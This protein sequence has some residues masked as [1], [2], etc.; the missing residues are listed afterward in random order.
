[1]LDID[2]RILDIITKYTPEKLAEEIVG[3]Q[4]M[5]EEVGKAV[6]FLSENDWEITVK[7]NKE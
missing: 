7:E 2:P 1:V 4:P 5:N 6:K 3:V